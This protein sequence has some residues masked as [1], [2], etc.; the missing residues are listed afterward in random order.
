MD[1]QKKKCGDCDRFM[2]VPGGAPLCLDNRC[3]PHHEDHE[4]CDEFKSRECTYCDEVGYVR[5]DKY[6]QTMRYKGKMITFE[7]WSYRCEK[8]GRASEPGWMFY[9]NL[10][11]IEA[12]TREVSKDG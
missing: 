12:A 9:R 4:A 8:C 11:R 7:R 6:E 5:L 2:M 10:D 1:K 3:C